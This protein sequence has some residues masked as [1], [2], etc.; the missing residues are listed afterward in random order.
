MKFL[1]ALILLIIVIAIA[2]GLYLWYQKRTA[3]MPQP[4]MP[5]TP[6]PVA[7]PEIQDVVNYNDFT[8]SLAS[9]ESVDIRARVQGLL[10]QTAFE[11]GAFVK[12]GDLLFE[13]EPETY[14]ADRDRA[15][16]ALRS[17]QA[18]MERATQDYERVMQAVQSDAVSRQEVST[19]KAQRDMAE[20]AVLSAKAALDQAELNL[21]Y[22]RIESPLDGKISRNFVDEGNL[23]GAGENTLLA[24]IVKL[25]PIYVYFNAS[26][27]EYLDY[28]RNVRQEMA[29][30]P[31]QLPVYLSLANDE[32]YPLPGR[33]DYMDNRVDPET[34]TV[35]IRGVIPNPDHTL[36]PGMFV[37]IRVPSKMVRN[38][39]LI[40]QKAIMS[41]LGGKYVL[42]VD[43]NNILHRRDLKLG[44]VK[45]ELQVVEAGLD[46][47]EQLATG[48]FHFIRQGM[49]ITPLTGDGPPPGAD[50]A[51]PQGQPGTE[52]ASEQP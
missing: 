40:P 8:G 28:M 17:A 7:G 18:D 47:S 37:R 51:A 2:A 23:V 6:V 26:E 48:N 43:E 42:V 27:S 25:D 22:T 45:D 4:E 31:N 24:N 20:A 9:V 49:P 13:I 39:V 29:D 35:Q 36:Y 44:A 21:S 14:R 16:A 32:E 11:D 46:G 1:K 15:A 33:L 38:A 10:R 50:G 5:P 34:G 30:E 12:K 52:P 41:D 19:Y 3:P